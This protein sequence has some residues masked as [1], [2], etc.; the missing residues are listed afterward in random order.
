MSTPKLSQADSLS[1]VGLSAPMSREQVRA[2]VRLHQRLLAHEIDANTAAAAWKSADP[3]AALLAVEEQITGTAAQQSAQAAADQERQAR[4]DAYRA[5]LEDN[6][7]SAHWLDLTI[8][9]ARRERLRAKYRD[10]DEPP[11]DWDG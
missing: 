6:H 5:H 10:V 2:K 1:R 7:P 11:A 4:W 3:V 8:G 9:P